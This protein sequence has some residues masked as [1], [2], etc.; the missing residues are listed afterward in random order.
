MIA[1]LYFKIFLY[2]KNQG[3]RKGKPLTNRVDQ[4]QMKIDLLPGSHNNKGRWI[5]LL[6]VLSYTKFCFM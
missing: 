4:E 5:T 6:P 1:N 2:A 3:K